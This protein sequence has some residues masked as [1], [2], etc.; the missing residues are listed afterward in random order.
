MSEFVKFLNA[1]SEDDEPTTKP[2]AEAMKME[3]KDRAQA[4]FDQMRPE[5]FPFRVGDIVMVRGGGSLNGGGDLAI[6]IEINV[7]GL[8]DTSKEFGHPAYMSPLNIR[9][10]R[11]L[12]G[13]YMPFWGEAA[14]YVLVERA[15]SA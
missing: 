5:T 14:N 6:V 12:S 3:L 15:P 2:D 9:V 4:Y 7:E 1:I 13:D 8:R 11:Y 10:L